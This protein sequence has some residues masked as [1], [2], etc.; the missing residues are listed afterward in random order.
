M[1]IIRLSNHVAFNADYILR[2]DYRPAQ[3]PSDGAQ[4][5]LRFI[6]TPDNMEFAGEEADRL[7]RTLTSQ[8]PAEGR[9]DVTSF[10]Q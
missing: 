9:C 6:G 8:G 1:H 5:T 7:W 10:D 3:D 2:A 4:I